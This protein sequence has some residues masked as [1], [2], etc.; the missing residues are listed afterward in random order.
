[1]TSFQFDTETLSFLSLQEYPDTWNPIGSSDFDELSELLQSMGDTENLVS[2]WSKLL[3]FVND[4]GTAQIPEQDFDPENLLLVKAENGVLQ[5]VYGPVIFRGLPPYDEQLILKVGGNEYQVMQ[6]EDKLQ[7]GN[8]KGGLRFE[9]VK[10]MDGSITKA[11]CSL[12]VQGETD[13]FLIPCALDSETN[14]DQGVIEA[15]MEQR[16]PIHRYFRSIPTGTSILKMQELGEGEYLVKDIEET[17]P[18]EYGKNFILHLVNAPSVWARGNVQNMLRLGWKLPQ[19]QP[20]TLAINKITQTS[21]G[22]RVNCA[23]WMREP[24]K[25]ALLA[26]QGEATVQPA[27]L[28]PAKESTV[29]DMMAETVSGDSLKEA[30]PF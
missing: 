19:G 21:N 23:L 28:Q 14:P 26:N 13:T 29:P 20:V 18:G 9:T 6:T 15:A 11:T 22:Y 25:A 3:H 30:I 24:R 17:E 12:R 5:R 7:V 4:I 27:Q 10:T 8:L 16:Q 2:A 1:M